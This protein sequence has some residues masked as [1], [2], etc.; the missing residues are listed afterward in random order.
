MLT[1][2]TCGLVLAL[3]VLLLLH[4]MAA[5]MRLPQQLL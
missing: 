1:V 5:T 4:T 3:Q 2:L